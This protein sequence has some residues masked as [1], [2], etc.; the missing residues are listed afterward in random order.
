MIKD[1]VYLMNP[2]KNKK[3]I[4]L[5]ERGDQK[6]LRQEINKFFYWKKPNYIFGTA[7]IIVLGIYF[8]CLFKK[9]GEIIL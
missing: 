2:K 3:Q 5:I 9:I 8:F 7:V 4:V 1:R 6:K